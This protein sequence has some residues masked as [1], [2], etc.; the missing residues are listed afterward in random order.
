MRRLLLIVLPLL[1]LLGGG[2]TLLVWATQ[3]EVPRE[4]RLEVLSPHWEGIQYEFERAFKDYIRR[5]EDGREIDIVWLDVGGGTSTIRDYILTRYGK[6]NPDMEESGLQEG[7]DVDILFGGGGRL[8]RDFMLHGEHLLE[9]YEPPPEILRPIPDS[10]GGIEI[11]DREGRWYGAALSTFGIIYNDRIVEN[12]NLPVPEDWRD[13]GAPRAF[14][15]VASGDPSSSGSVAMLYELILQTYG[16]TDGYALICRIG[17][18]VQAF[19]EGGAAAPKSVAI[20]QAAY[21]MCIDFY[22]QAEEAWVGPENLTFTLPTGLNTVTPDPIAIMR[23]PGNPELAR[24]FV[25]FVLS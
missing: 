21:G 9:S 25:D 18:N 11:Y 19:D 24:K 8:H 23:H 5:T 3:N 12:L 20:G 15:W 2:A 6:A 1:I 22:G 4:D 17:G 13:L 10:I 7:I 14:G 16:L